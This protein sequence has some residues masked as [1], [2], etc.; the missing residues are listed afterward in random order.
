LQLI[1]K[2]ILNGE[3]AILNGEKAIL[4][5]EKAIFRANKPLNF[6]LQ[7]TPTAY[8]SFYNKDI[9]EEFV[10]NPLGKSS[11]SLRYFYLN[12]SLSL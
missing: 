9:Y 3:K 5:G 12:L 11:L 4:N 10:P 2:A 7:T 6:G 8:Y 1:F